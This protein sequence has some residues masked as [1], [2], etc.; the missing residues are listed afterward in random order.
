MQFE[1]TTNRSWWIRSYPA[2][3]QTRVLKFHEW[4][5]VCRL[6][7]NDPPTAV[8]GIPNRLARRLCRLGMNHPPTAVGGIP[9]RL[10]GRLCRLGMNHPPTAVGGIQ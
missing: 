7:M 10:A 2:Y 6:G 3:H 4:P 8:G 1:N 5:F 9:N